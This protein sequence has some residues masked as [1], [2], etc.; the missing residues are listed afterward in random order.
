MR[1]EFLVLAV[2]GALLPILFF[3]LGPIA[4]PAG[5]HNFADQRP[6]LA[7]S[8]F[9]N[10]VSNLPFLIIGVMGLHL[11]WRKR[12]EAAAAWATLFAGTTMVAFGSSWY[13]SDPNDETLIWDRVPMGI[14][15]MGFFAALLIEHLNG[16]RRRVT[17][18]LLVPGV[19]FSAATIWWWYRSGD[20]SL[21]AW[22]QAA[23]MLAVVLVLVLLPARYTHRR[24]LAYGLA[25]YVAAKVFEVA[26]VQFMQWTGGLMSGHA[27][28]H[29]AAAAGAWC[30]YIM[31]R[32]RSAIGEVAPVLIAHD[33]RELHHL[34]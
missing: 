22:V 25:C 14:A 1:R 3:G 18:H 5:Y 27:M 30:L 32:R 4:Q 28:K 2:L 19:A 7:I 24:Y 10:V 13:H 31:L 6:V 34:P 9:W 29:L 21:W 15:F 8:H 23:P 16:V 33:S 12:G 20:L 11:V 17:H 26:D